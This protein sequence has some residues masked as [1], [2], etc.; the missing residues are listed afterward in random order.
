M[1]TQDK[2]IAIAEM[3]GWKYVTWMDRRD[4][5]Y[6]K[7]IYEGWYSRVPNIYN[8]KINGELYKGRSHN[9]LKFHSDANWQ[10]EAIEWI[11]Q[12]DVIGAKYASNYNVVVDCFGCYIETTGYHSWT[13]V[14]VE[15]E[16]RKETIFEALYQFSQYLK[17]KK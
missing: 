12:Q 15:N 4:E 7:T 14:R 13:V 1:T 3:L 11:Q 5:K 17:Q 6:G 2:N 8:R 9:N 16:N 10:D